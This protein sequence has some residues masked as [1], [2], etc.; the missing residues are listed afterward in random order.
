[1][2]RSGSGSRRRFVLLERA[3]GRAWRVRHWRRIR[4]VEFRWGWQHEEENKGMDEDEG[5]GYTGARVYVTTS[6]N[7]FAASLKP[8][9]KEAIWRQLGE[10][11]MQRRVEKG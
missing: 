8:P 10:W 7:G 1:M 5:E 3:F 4:K 2:R 11:V 6:T 9:E